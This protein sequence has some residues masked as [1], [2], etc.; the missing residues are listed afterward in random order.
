MGIA[1]G[2]RMSIQRVQKIINRAL[3]SS[4]TLHLGAMLQ[5]AAWEQHPH[6]TG[7]WQN[8]ALLCAA[9]PDPSA[10]CWVD[11]ERA[12]WSHTISKGHNNPLLS[13]SEW[14]QSALLSL[15]CYMVQKTF[16][17]RKSLLETTPRQVCLPAHS[18]D[19]PVQQE[20]ERKSVIV[21]YTSE[22][23]LHTV[24]Q[25]LLPAVEVIH[26]PWLAR[27]KMPQK[28]NPCFQEKAKRC[29][30]RD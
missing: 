18:T 4:V 2:L 11:G 21:L 12:A 30:Q 16:C 1:R 10:D 5:E 15:R 8:P 20:G 19:R 3:S 25:S 27:S 6:E 29:A 23:R 26:I 13:A 28:V 7:F 9:Q 22:G 14:L 17:P 24:P